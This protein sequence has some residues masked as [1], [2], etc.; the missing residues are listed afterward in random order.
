MNRSKLS[1]VDIKQIVEQL[2]LANNSP[3][4]ND[5]YCLH[6]SKLTLSNVEQYL[7]ARF[8]VQLSYEIKKQVEGMCEGYIRSH[9]VKYC[10]QVCSYLFITLL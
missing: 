8:V 10:E 9:V 2:L 6:D 5:V 1:P 3:N 4:S 7:E